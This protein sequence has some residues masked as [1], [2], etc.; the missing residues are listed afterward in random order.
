MG[1]I[2]KSIDKILKIHD[3]TSP[4][5]CKDLKISFEIGIPFVS[6]ARIEGKF[7]I[8]EAEK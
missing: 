3:D 8:R 1:F 5:K 4:V 2:K 6:K 7:E